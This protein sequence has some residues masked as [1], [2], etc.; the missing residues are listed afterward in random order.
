MRL[1]AVSDA[2]WAMY[3]RGREKGN[4][5]KLEGD[6]LRLAKDTAIEIIDIV[7]NNHSFVDAAF[8]AAAAHDQESKED[9][10]MLIEFVGITGITMSLL[11]TEVALN[12]SKAWSNIKSRPKYTSILG[13]IYS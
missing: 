11:S 4:N 10:I 5:D 3:A 8:E 2:A 1:N 13:A 9:K 6:A 12:W 7:T